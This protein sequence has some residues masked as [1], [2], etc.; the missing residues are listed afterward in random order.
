MTDYY[1]ED[2]GYAGAIDC[3]Q[4]IGGQLFPRRGKDGSSTVLCGKQVYTFWE[5]NSKNKAK[6]QQLAL[7]TGFPHE[8]FTSGR[9]AKHILEDVCGVDPKLGK[10]DPVFIRLA[11][12]GFHWHY[13]YVSPGYYPY[14]LEF[15]L[16][17][18]YASSLVKYDSP[19][20]AMNQPTISAP[21]VMENLRVALAT[22]PKWMRMILIGQL[23]AH[24]MHYLTMPKR[25]SGDFTLKL[26]TIHKIK[27]GY[28]FN[29]A[30][31]SVLRV[32]RIFQRIHEIGGNS[33]KRIHTDSFTLSADCPSEIERQIF[34]Y[35]DN[36][37]FG[38]SCKAQGTAH[39]FSLN[40]GIV[41]RKF[42]GV[43]LE[44]RD[45]LRAL[46]E[47]PK[48]HFITPEQLERWG[49]RGVVDDTPQRQPHIIEPEQ[50]SIEGL[51][52]DRRTSGEIYERFA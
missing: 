47:K 4:T 11:K 8:H 46:P 26:N 5:P 14:L 33:I 31:Q 16:C 19:Y 15:D 2:T 25:S 39:F 52:N 45:H 20:F 12:D 9:I 49:L 38:Y 36:Q 37:G 21:L 51:T 35:L 3:L 18:A 10:P 24:R 44:I 17:A 22:V 42:V 43:P 13:T 28:A 30:H 27:Y 23:T 41:G 7:S 32:Y 40:S 6:C 29:R 34:E 48:R 1:T 50:L